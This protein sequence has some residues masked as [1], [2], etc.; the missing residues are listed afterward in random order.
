MALARLGQCGSSQPGINHWRLVSKILVHCDRSRWEH[1][2]FLSFKCNI[3]LFL[4]MFFYLSIEHLEEFIHFFILG[5]GSWNFNR[6]LSSLVIIIVLLYLF[7]HHVNLS[8]NC[9]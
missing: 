3:E 1:S 7:L 8:K 6:F 4:V 9:V 2:R 5:L